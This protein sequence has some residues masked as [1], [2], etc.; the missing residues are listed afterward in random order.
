M[1]RIFLAAGLILSMTFFTAILSYADSNVINGCYKKINGQLRILNGTKRCLKSEIPISW[2]ITGSEGEPGPS[3]VVATYALGGAADTITANAT[4]FVFAGTT[5]SIT[6]TDTQRITGVVQAP[7]GTN[8]T[9]GNASFNYDLCYRTAGTSNALTS[10][11]AN[12][13]QG[14]VS[15]AA[16]RISFTA[17]A[18]VVPG[19][20]TWEAGYCVM[21][22]GTVDLD[23]NDFVNGWLV[24]TND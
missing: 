9:S 10:F 2:N 15:N 22:S 13:S 24:L 16:G 12:P 23:N 5:T 19:A 7:L 3:G 4:Q 17:A 1:K 8:S 21:N 6:T 20:G 14:I 18:S 11:S